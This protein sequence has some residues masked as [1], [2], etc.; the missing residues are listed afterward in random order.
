[1][2]SWPTYASAASAL[3]Y[4]TMRSTSSSLVFSTVPAET[5]STDT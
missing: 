5:F 3:S 4:V 1:M 2:L